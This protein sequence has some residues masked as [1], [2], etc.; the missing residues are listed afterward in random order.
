MLSF[1]VVIR[2]EPAIVFYNHLLSRRLEDYLYDLIGKPEHNGSVRPPPFLQVDGRVQSGRR[3]V[4]GA[5]SELN[6]FEFL[7]AVEEALEVLQQYHLFIDALRVIEEVVVFNSFTLRALLTAYVGEVKEVRV[8][9][10]LAG[11]VK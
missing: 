5:K 10:Y 3:G 6:R 1:C 4:L 9:D 8:E 7:V 11:V 2:D